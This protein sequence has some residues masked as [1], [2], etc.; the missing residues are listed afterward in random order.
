V[1]RLCAPAVAQ[2][3][4]TSSLISSSVQSRAVK[5]RSPDEW[6]LGRVVI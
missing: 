3:S 1:T 6:V 4:A 2:T 5:R